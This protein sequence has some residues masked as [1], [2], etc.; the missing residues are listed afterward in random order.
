[1]ESQLKSKTSDETLVCPDCRYS[2]RPSTLGYTCDKCSKDF[3]R[4][5][6][7][8]SFINELDLQDSYSIDK[9]QKLIQIEQK[10]FWHVVRK[11]IIYDFIK[12]S[13]MQNQYT[14]NIADMKMLEV[15]CGTGNVLSYLNQ[16]GI[17]V[18]GGDRYMEGLEFCRNVIEEDLYQLDICQLPFHQHTK[19]PT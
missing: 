19:T 8:I 1:M 5:R 11:K 3:P 7:I 4:K 17:S 6:G 10:H 12:K 18:E 16:K 14:K 9:Y 2:L 13:Y 15:G